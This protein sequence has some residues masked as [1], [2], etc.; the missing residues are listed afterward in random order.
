MEGELLQQQLLPLVPLLQLSA[1][2]L[3][4]LAPSNGQEL[5]EERSYSFPQYKV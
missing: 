5:S 4:K 2:L 1:M 3:L